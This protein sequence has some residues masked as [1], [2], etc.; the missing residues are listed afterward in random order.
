MTV[1]HELNFMVWCCRQNIEI[2]S[3]IFKSYAHWSGLCK[4]KD[5]ITK[6]MFAE[7]KLFEE[8]LS[9]QTNIQSVFI[10]KM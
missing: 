3:N 7:K 6:T 5:K 4:N 10:M 2:D 1:S 8:V 9:L